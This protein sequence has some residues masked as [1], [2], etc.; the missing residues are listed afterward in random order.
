MKGLEIPAAAVATLNGG[1]RPPIVVTINGHSW[2]TRV[3]IMRGRHLIGLSNANRHAAGVEIGATI[4]VEVE[5][6][7]ES[8]VAEVPPDLA[9]SLDADPLARR[10]FDA[11]SESVRR[12]HVR[13]IESA[14]KPETRERRIAT[15]LASLHDG[16]TTP[17]RSSN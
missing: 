16:A 11:L 7:L 10:A 1:K 12:E 9:A 3:A 5:L 17:R 13:A 6:D 4:D 8:R 15:A 14:K 2:R